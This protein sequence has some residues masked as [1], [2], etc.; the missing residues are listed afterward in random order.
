M[1]ARVVV[2]S[3]VPDPCD[4]LVL[5]TRGLY[6][7]VDGAGKWWPVTLTSRN[8][9]FVRAEV[10]DGAGTVCSHL[11]GTVQVADR[12]GQLHHG[13][14]PAICGAATALCATAATTAACVE[15]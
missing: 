13:E 2:G 3:G 15:K 11:R 6:E 8:G 4:D 10:H 12:M 9:E 1:C 14:R 7:A 5:N